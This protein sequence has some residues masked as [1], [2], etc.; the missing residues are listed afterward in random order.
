MSLSFASMIDKIVQFADS[1][2][3]G[4]IVVVG[5]GVIGTFVKSILDS[6]KSI[7]LFVD[8]NIH[9]QSKGWLSLPV[10][11]PSALAEYD[12]L[13]K[14]KYI[15]AHNSKMIPLALK[16]LPHDITEDRVLSLF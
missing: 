15:I 8:S 7:D 16:M 14:P 3:E 9:K 12:K 6:R 2:Q 1:S 10:I 5:A 4:P 11:S 13:N